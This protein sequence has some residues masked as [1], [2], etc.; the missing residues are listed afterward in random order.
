ME[1]LTQYFQSKAIK[2]TVYLKVSILTLSTHPGVDGKPDKFLWPKKKKE[3]KKK[4][5][6]ELNSEIA[7]QHS[8]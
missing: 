2:G 8:S 1:I 4:T 3:K 6:L 5:F 7:L